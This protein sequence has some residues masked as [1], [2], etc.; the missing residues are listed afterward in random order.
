MDSDAPAATVEY[1]AGSEDGSLT[2]AP[3]YAYLVPGGEPITVLDTGNLTLDTSSGEHN[4]QYYYTFT[5]NGS[6][7]FRF[8]DAAGNIGTATAT[9]RTINSDDT[10]LELVSGPVWLCR[11]QTYTSNYNW[12]TAQ[13]TLHSNTPVTATFTANLP[14]ASAE[15]IKDDESIP[16]E[17]VDVTVS[18]NLIRVTYS[19]NCPSVRLRAVAQNGQTFKY[20]Y[21]SSGLLYAVTCLDMDAPTVTVTAPSSP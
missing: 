2:K 3:V 6:Y 21:G 4:G 7:T 18:G 9:V 1:A 12:Q 15:I 10:A 19:V 5:A 14:L 20:T 16:T 8:S 11:G 17:G 13:Q